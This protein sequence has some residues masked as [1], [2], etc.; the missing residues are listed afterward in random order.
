LCGLDA[1]GTTRGTAIADIASGLPSDAY[2]R[3]AIAPIL[4]NEP[5]VFFLSGLQNICED[6]A[7]Q[8]VDASPGQGALG[9]Q[10]WSSAQP[11][12]A[13]RDFV[14]GVMGLSSADPRAAPAQALLEEHF[15]ASLREPGITATQALRS[16]FV[17]ACLSPSSVSIGL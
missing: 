5:T 1:L 6:V 13:I 12:A 8:V 11:E 15:S 10:R 16:T 3:G 2:G 14:S 9:V 4:P 17:V 7:E